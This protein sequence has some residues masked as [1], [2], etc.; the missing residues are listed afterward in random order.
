MICRESGAKKNQTAIRNDLD[1]YS[2]I[3]IKLSVGQK[4]VPMLSA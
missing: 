2:Q 4:L 3:A 1:K